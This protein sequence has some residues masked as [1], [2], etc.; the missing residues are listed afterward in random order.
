MINKLFEKQANKT[1]DNVAFIYNKLHLNYQ[2]LNIRTN[3]LAN[4]LLVINLSLKKE[5][6][7]K[8]VHKSIF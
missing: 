7:I 6:I 4:Y 3:K 1:P 8:L 2:K 5:K